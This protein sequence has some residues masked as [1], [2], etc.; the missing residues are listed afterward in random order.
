MHRTAPDANLRAVRCGV[1]G[2]LQHYPYT[3]RT[4]G[5]DF[6]YADDV[7]R[8]GLILGQSLCGMLE[9]LSL[10]T[11]TRFVE[12]IYEIFAATGAQTFNEL[13]SALVKNA[14]AVLRHLREIAPEDFK[15]L[16]P[17]IVAFWQS[18]AQVLRSVLM[19]ES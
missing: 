4:E 15:L 9:K 2:L 13:G 8:S 12:A 10:E 3:W 11:R 14:P 7:G 16:K 6:R 1:P 19:E 18:V 5:L 17:V